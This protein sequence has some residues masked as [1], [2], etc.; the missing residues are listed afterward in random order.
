MMSCSTKESFF[1]LRSSIFTSSSHSLSHDFQD[2]G[3]I[4][5]LTDQTLKEGMGSS[6]PQGAQ[7]S[8]VTILIACSLF[9]FAVIT[10]IPV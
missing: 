8:A 9:H 10:V 3:D 7:Q 5:L 6:N 2:L 1:I 4:Y